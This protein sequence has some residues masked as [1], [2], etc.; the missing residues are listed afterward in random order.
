M[1]MN[2]QVINRWRIIQLRA[3]LR[4]LFHYQ[5]RI[6]KVSQGQIKQSPKSGLQHS[7]TPRF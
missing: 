6:K 5:N 4:V 3:N 7:K 2:I 1:M